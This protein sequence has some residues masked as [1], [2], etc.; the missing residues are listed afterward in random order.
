MFDSSEKK[1]V[2]LTHY[3]QERTKINQTWEVK[4]SIL[5]KEK[6]GDLHTGK[7]NA[8]VGFVLS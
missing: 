7:K 2:Q 1:K 5:W 3:I 8:V 4:Q 6:P